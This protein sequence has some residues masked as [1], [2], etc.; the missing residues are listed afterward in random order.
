MKWRVASDLL[1]Q[2][3]VSLSLSISK[4]Q[5]K[6]GPADFDEKLESKVQNL[7][8]VPCSLEMKDGLT[9]LFFF[10][11]SRMTFPGKKKKISSEECGRF[12]PNQAYT[13]PPSQCKSLPPKAKLEEQL[14]N[15]FSGA[16]R[17]SL[18]KIPHSNILSSLIVN[19][20]APSRYAF[21]YWH[22][23]KMCTILKLW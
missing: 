21:K 11:S 18:P 15:P 23:V 14:L 8:N 16:Q 20:P 22:T 10:I 9:L 3:T 1:F 17:Q 2:I 12:I 6:H 19:K 13:F 7:V 5:E 4:H